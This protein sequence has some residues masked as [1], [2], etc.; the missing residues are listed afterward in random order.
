MSARVAFL[1]RPIGENEQKPVTAVNPGALVQKDGK[2]V[3]YVVKGDAVAETSLSAGDP[4][5]DLVEV[6]EG[7][8]PGDKVVLHPPR[9]LKTGAK[10]SVPA[11]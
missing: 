7:L 11:S 9:K 1:E 2:T 3:A 6:R 8:K 10:I 5:G 4:V